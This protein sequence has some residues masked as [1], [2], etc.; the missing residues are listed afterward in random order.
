[1]RGNNSLWTIRLTQLGK[2]TLRWTDTFF[3]IL[4][5]KH[6]LLDEIQQAFLFAKMQFNNT[7]YVWAKES[8]R[9]IRRE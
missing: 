8:A 4:F 5:D 3:I 7:V 2:Q 6:Y 1:M 9:L